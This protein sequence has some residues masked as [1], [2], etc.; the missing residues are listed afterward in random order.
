[1]KYPVIN[2]KTISVNL[3]PELQPDTMQTR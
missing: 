3:G 1:V 2:L